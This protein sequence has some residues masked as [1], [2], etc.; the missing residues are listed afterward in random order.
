MSPTEKK[1]SRSASGAP[2]AGRAGKRAAILAG[3]LRV[4]ARDGYTRASIDA[5]AGEA[6]VSTRTIYNHFADKA[7]LFRTVIGDSAR[8]VAEAEVAL[9]DTYLRDGADPEA[10][11]T[12]FAHAWLTPEQVH[13]DHFAL[14]RQIT[15]ETG[16]VP[17][18]AIQAW[19]EAGPLRVRYALADRLSAWSAGGT[20]AVDDAVHAA[21]HLA[22]LISAAIPGPTSGAATPGEA[23]AWIAS[24][25]R[26]FLRGYGRE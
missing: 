20:L 23:D 15:A 19:R 8:K 11:L 10:E 3:A 13:A 7:D 25:V 1:S 22:Q 5:I 14:I 17:D 6:A 4:F 12:A 21:V 26:A 9:I 2:T 24:G 16:H 18:A